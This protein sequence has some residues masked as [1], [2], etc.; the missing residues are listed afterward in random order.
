MEIPQ[1]VTPDGYIHSIDGPLANF[2]QQSASPVNDSQPLNKPTKA[3]NDRITL[4]EEESGI[5]GKDSALEKE[6]AVNGKNSSIEK[7]SAVNGEGYA[8]GSLHREMLSGEFRDGGGIKASFIFPFAS[9]YIRCAIAENKP[10]SFIG[11]SGNAQI[12]V[13]TDQLS[14]DSRPVFESSDI[15]LEGQIRNLNPLLDN[16][17]ELFKKGDEI[18]RLVV[19]DPEMRIHDVR[20]YLHKRLF[21]G[22]EVSRGY[23]EGFEIHQETDPLTGKVC[24]YITIDLEPYQYFFE[25]Y[26]INP[27]SINAVIKEGRSALSKIRSL[28]P[29]DINSEK[30]SLKPG[31]LFVGAIKISLGDVYAIIDPVAEPELHDIEHLPARVLDPFR[32]FRERQVELF[33][34]GNREVQLGKIKIKIRFFRARNP[35]TVPLEKAKVKEGYRLYDLLTN[36]EV[37]NL[38]L[39]IHENSLGMILN[40]GNFVQVPRAMDS[41][42]E[43][44]FEIIKS[45]VV[46]STFRKPELVL[47]VTGNGEFK[48]T[49]QKLSVLGGINSRAFI[50][51]SYPS[52]EIINALKRSGIRTFL[53]NSPTPAF[54]DDYIKKMIRLTHMELSACEFLRYDSETDKLYTFYHGCFMEPDDRERFDRVRYWFAFYG[55]HTNEAD[56][57]LTIDVLNLLAAKLG[58]EMGIAHGG[59]PGLMKE[60]NDLAR[61]HNIMSVGIAIDL[62]GERQASLTTCDGLIKYKEGLRLA[63]QDH[64]QKLSNLPIINTGGYGSAEELSITITSMKL[65]E[66]PLAPI[67]LLDPDNLWEHARKQTIEIS[68]KKYG[69]TFIPKLLKPC[70]TAKDAVREIV[71]FLANPDKWYQDNNIPK[72]AV[73]KTREKSRRI[74]METFGHKSVEL[75][76]IPNPR[77]LGMPN[78]I[79]KKNINK[80]A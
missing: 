7:E 3:F 15:F 37:S 60:S 30:A 58:D 75:F 35:L 77:L 64:L 33:N 65:H 14:P 41:G 57:R 56:N 18:G 2:L 49:L 51:T 21:V 29:I 25:P 54:D 67:I 72:E 36:G 4:E 55:S 76:D 28:A 1:I 17:L 32:T 20:H 52:P 23:Y 24:D 9:D 6:G 53:I 44:Q 22:R 8:T 10:Y 68:L 47:P 70:P 69:P 39:S 74:R 43:A 59:G 16:V 26:A 80:N 66:N 38:F 5:N 31:E 45:A 73:D 46:Q 63:R 13:L 40:K 71:L 19:M 62:E 78:L 61:K 48:K 79:T 11:R 50:G 42:G 34:F 27:S 12:G